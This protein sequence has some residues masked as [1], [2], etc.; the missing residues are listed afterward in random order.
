[1]KKLKEKTPTL[2]LEVVADYEL[3]IWHAFFGLPG[4][5]NDINVFNHSPL[6]SRLCNGDSP[7]VEFDI[8]DH[9]YTQGYYLADGIYPSYAT[10]VKTISHPQ[11]EM[12]SYYAAMQEGQRKDVERAFGVLQA[13]FS[14]LARPVKFMNEE[15]LG[16]IMKAC[17]ILHNMIIEDERN[18]EG[19]EDVEHF[20]ENEADRV[21]LS[22]NASGEVRVTDFLTRYFDIR[23]DT[24]HEKLKKDL[25]LYLWSEKAKKPVK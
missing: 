20:D 14:I 12:E 24:V 21:V 23:D 5:L 15:D 18:I 19:L 9:H 4:S 6:F 11:N 7:Q 22:Q 2:I 25:M 13:R 10:L 1:M 8:F 17:I 3:W 16:W